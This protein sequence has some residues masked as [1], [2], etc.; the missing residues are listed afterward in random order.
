MPISPKLNKMVKRYNEQ[1]E[2]PK[3]VVKRQ[4]SLANQKMQAIQI[5]KEPTNINPE[6]E[7][8]ITK[9]YKIM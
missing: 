5:E 3:K 6:L 9:K 1:L 2:E 8:L 4:R 7:T